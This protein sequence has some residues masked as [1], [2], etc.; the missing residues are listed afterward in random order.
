MNSKDI[1]FKKDE[2]C[3]NFRVSCIIKKDNKYLLHRKLGDD[4][5]N[6][7]GGRVELGESSIEA[8]KREISE[9]IKCDCIINDMI[10]VCENFFVFKNRIYHEILMIFSG[11]LKGDFC[12][13]NIEEG[14]EF[15]WFDRDELETLDIKPHFTK[16]ILLDNKHEDWWIVNNELN[17][18]I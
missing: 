6:L 10:K 16:E 17:Q 5:W 18:Y 7:A 12:E 13:N 9:E 14:L 2:V 15:C 1:C 4:F 3:F 8:I 11:E